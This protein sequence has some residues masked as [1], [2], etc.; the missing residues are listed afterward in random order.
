MSECL[1]LET[2]HCLLLRMILVMIIMSVLFIS[3]PKPSPLA[4]PP[5]LQLLCC[6]PRSVYSQLASSNFQIFFFKGL[7]IY[8]HMPCLQP[9]SGHRSIF[10]P[11]WLIS[12]GVCMLLQNLE[13]KLFQTSLPALPVVRDRRC[14]LV[15]PLGWG[16]FQPKLRFCS[17]CYACVLIICAKPGIRTDRFIVAAGKADQRTPQ[18]IS[19]DVLNKSIKEFARLSTF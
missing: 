14:S 7:F 5:W 8:F 1:L 13:W 4:P 19:I 17:T 12:V 10:C 15:A 6:L 9:S 16:R 18:R 2:P 11:L 3:D